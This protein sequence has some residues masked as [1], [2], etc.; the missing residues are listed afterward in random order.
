MKKRLV[1][2]L[3]IILV[4]VLFAGMALGSGSTD[5]DNGKKEIGDGNEAKEEHQEVNES[6]S[7]EPVAAVTIEEQVLVEQDGIK[8]TALEMTEDSIWGEGVKLLIEN[9]SDKN[10]GVGC[11][12]LIVNN[13]MITD[14]FS[15]L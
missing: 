3:W 11:N 5:K 2:K 6:E 15:Y 13:Y 7:E 9:D 8:I 12:A 14:L 1:G 4:F 10:I